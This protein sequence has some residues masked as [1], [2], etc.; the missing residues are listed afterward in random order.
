M[1]F[2]ELHPVVHVEVDTSVLFL[3][4]RPTTTAFRR[5]ADALAR[6]ALTEGQSMDWI[7]G[8]A[9]ELGTPRREHDEKAGHDEPGLAEEFFQ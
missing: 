8:L 3:E 1:E 2:T 9:R 4:R 5:I 6:V 7:A